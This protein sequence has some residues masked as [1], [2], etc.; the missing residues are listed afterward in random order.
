MD[1]IKKVSNIKNPYKDTDI[2]LQPKLRIAALKSLWKL[3]NFDLQTKKNGNTKV[4]NI[5]A[6]NPE[7]T[8]LFEK[9]KLSPKD[10]KKID[11]LLLNDFNTLQEDLDRAVKC[12]DISKKLYNTERKESNKLLFELGGIFKPQSVVEVWRKTKEFCKRNKTHVAIG[13]AVLFMTWAAMMI[14]SPGNASAQA[15]ESKKLVQERTIQVENVSQKV[16]NFTLFQE[17]LN[18]ASF[19][20][21]DNIDPSSPSFD[22]SKKLYLWFMKTFISDIDSNWSVTTDIE[23]VQSLLKAEYLYNSW[24]KGNLVNKSWNLSWEDLK[25]NEI[26]IEITESEMDWLKQ[27]HDWILIDWFDF[28]YTKHGIDINVVENNG[29]YT[30]SW[31]WQFNY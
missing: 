3:Q 17:T 23:W 14:N 16:D 10:M 27:A 6:W 5:F 25:Q 26:K 29:E 24:I 13:S 15:S 2:V 18:S 8:Q 9:E 22:K 19:Q 21:F 20:E 12:H 31:L 4:S 7:L 11:D 30:I 28:S 1:T